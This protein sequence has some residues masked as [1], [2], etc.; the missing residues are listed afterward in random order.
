MDRKRSD[1]RSTPQLLQL[2]DRV[3]PAVGTFPPTANDDFID[4]D[5]NNP[6]TID[7]LVN[8][9]AVSGKTLA[10]STVQIV[11]APAHG[12]ATVNPANGKV[13]YTATGFFLG[14]DTLRYTV[15]DSAGITSVPA[16]R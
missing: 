5:G 8:D 15:K 13:S 9:V 2:E 1:R 12:T 4:T 16:N 10:A 11:T 14:T 3:T 7:V 6:V